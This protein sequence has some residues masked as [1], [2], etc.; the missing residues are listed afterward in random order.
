MQINAHSAAINLK[1][2]NALL[3]TG[4]YD[5]KKVT[6]KA[7]TRLFYGTVALVGPWASDTIN[8]D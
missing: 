6:I 8:F 7:R 4:F 5:I 3:D 1:P 2:D